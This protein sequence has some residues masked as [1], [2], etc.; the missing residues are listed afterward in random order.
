MLAAMN[1]SWPPKM[2]AAGRRKDVRSL[3]SSF[4]FTNFVA[5]CTVPTDANNAKLRVD[6]D[7]HRQRRYQVAFSW[8]EFDPEYG[9]APS[10]LAQPAMAH[11]KTAEPPSD[12]AGSQFTPLDV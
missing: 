5:D 2:S 1:R 7:G 3:S 11:T 4:S 10:L 9:A 8:G 6:R 12:P